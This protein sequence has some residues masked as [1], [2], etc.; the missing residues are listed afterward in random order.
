MIAHSRET[1]KVTYTYDKEGRILTTTTV[2]VYETK[3]QDKPVPE[4]LD[5]GG[6]G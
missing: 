4:L 2:V 1:T 3:P 5:E 6:R